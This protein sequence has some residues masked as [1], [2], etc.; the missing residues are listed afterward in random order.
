MKKILKPIIYIALCAVSF[1]I[2]RA[3]LIVIL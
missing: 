3:A 2:L 1:M